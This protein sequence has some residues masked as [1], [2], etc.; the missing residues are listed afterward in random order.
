MPRCGTETENNFKLFESRK[1]LFPVIPAKV[2]RQAQDCEPAEQPDYRRF[3]TFWMPSHR[4]AGHAP[5]VRHDDFDT[6]YEISKIFAPC[7][8]ALPSRL[9]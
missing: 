7:K 5:Q 1:V 2:L 9:D 4:D 8:A 3:S 6:F